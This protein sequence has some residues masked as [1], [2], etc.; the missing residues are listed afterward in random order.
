MRGHY[1]EPSLGYLD[2]DLVDCQAN[3]GWRDDEQHHDGE[4]EASP[5]KMLLIDWFANLA[6]FL[7][8]A[9]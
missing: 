4:L 9:N 1:H 8:Q 3:F 2:L 7:N 6:S 5:A